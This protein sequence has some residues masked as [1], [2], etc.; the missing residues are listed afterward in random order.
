M[1]SR[2]ASLCH[3]H[4]RPRLIDGTSFASGSD[5]VLREAARL[6]IDL[7]RIIKHRRDSKVVARGV[8]PTWG[9]VI[10]KVCDPVS[11]APK[12]YTQLYIDSLL[13]RYPAELFP[14]TLAFGLGY[15]V[16]EF[17]RGPTAEDLH[18][19]ELEAIELVQFVEELRTWCS[20]STD[21]VGILAEYECR[22]ILRGYVERSLRRL[23]YK[24][25]YAA[26]RAWHQLT[27]KQWQI[28]GRIGAL[29]EMTQG[30][31]LRRTTMVG[32][33]H[34]LNLICSRDSGRLVIVD[35]EE[36]RPGNYTFDATYLLVCLLLE[37]G[38]TPTLEELAQRVFCSAYAGGDDAAEFFRAVASYMLTVF[39]VVDNHDSKV[40]RST[41]AFLDSP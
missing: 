31:S 36:I 5:Q 6:E 1:R 3:R 25:G 41:T 28:R 8:P 29:V 19:D 23:R 38:V 9:D 18:P 14:R 39:M 16:L 24:S 33:M 20:S 10:L 7:V 22:S 15:S 12:A 21:A 35:N 17:K 30:L 13:T 34:P 26:L 2:L 37:Y 11:T 27:A 32:D 40:I 4:I